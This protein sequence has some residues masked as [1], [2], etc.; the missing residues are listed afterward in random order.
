MTWDIEI[1]LQSIYTGENV[2]S[3]NE[4]PDFYALT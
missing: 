1:E 3:F 4:G 2:I